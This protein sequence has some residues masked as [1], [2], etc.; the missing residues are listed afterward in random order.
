MSPTPRGTLR[1]VHCR[2]AVVVMCL[3]SVLLGP[4]PGGAQTITPRTVPVLMS[5]QFDILPSDRSGMAGVSIALDDTLL[6]PFVN[7]AKATRNRQGLLSI[8]PFFHS[9]SESRGGGRTLPISASGSFGKWAAGGLVAL[10]QLDRAQLA[11]NTPTSER[12]ASNRYLSGILARDLGSG[13]SVGASAYWADLGAE[14]GIDQM[15]AGSDR[16]Q[17]AGSAADLR[18]GMTKEWFGNRV[19]EALL[20]RS[21]FDMTHN[22]HFPEFQQ[23]TPTGNIIVS[24]ERSESHRDHTVRW[25]AHSE[26]SQPI[27]TEGWRIGFLGTVNR[28]SHPK[29]PDYRLNDVP[30]V[31]RDPGH[32]WGYNAGVGLSKTSGGSTFG[33]DVVL[34]PMYSTT[35]AEAANDTLT[36]AGQTIPRGGHTVDNRFRFSN[37]QVRF[38]FG[39]DWPGAADSSSGIGLQLGLGLNAVQYRL[40]QTDL[41]RDTSRVQDEHWMEWTPTLGFRWRGPVAEFRYTLSLTCGGGG[42]CLGCPFICSS[43]DD[44]SIAPPPAPGGVIAAPTAALRFAGGRV[45]THRLAFSLRIR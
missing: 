14:Q 36:T 8:A 21:R 38:G 32:T 6:D 3:S 33:V 7:P 5:H 2:A 22:V 27:G 39:H 34:E 43:G 17:Q 10:Q 28:L 19:F 42:E 1:S 20:L 18:V 31:P 37:S 29:I 26:Y 35:W 30:T 45:T 23:W 11:F 41:V 40:W 24:P 16:I 9:M 13:F 15:Y 44:V 4:A 12:T 25:G